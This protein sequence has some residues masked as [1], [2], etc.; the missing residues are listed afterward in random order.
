MLSFECRP[1]SLT[2]PPVEGL[3]WGILGDATRGGDW[4]GVSGCS[5]ETGKATSRGDV[6]PRKDVLVGIVDTGDCVNGIDDAWEDVVPNPL[7]VCAPLR[8]KL[9]SIDR[10]GASGTDG[11]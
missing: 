11:G 4:T 10:F 6:D 1:C 7:S 8:P 9:S 3:P 2:D 5:D